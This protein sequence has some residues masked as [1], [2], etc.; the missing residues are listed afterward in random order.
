MSN[1]TDR[2]HHVDEDSASL[3][4]RRLRNPDGPEAAARIA[5][6]EAEVE[7]LKARIPDP[8]DES[9]RS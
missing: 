3:F 9:G 8:A 1:L 7:R 5:N 4:G 2:L 6:L